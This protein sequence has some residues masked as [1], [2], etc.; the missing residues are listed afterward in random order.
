MGEF[1]G[2]RTQPGQP[3]GAARQ[4]FQNREGFLISEYRHDKKTLS[5]VNIIVL[6]DP[7]R[8]SFRISLSSWNSALVFVCVTG[9]LGAV[10]YAGIQF[11]SE[12]STGIVSSLREQTASIW[13]DELRAQ[14]E[15]L[16]EVKANAEWSLD[17]MA[18]RV[19]RLQ[20]H[21]MRLDALGSRL[22][23][24]AKLQ[25]M[26]F[27][28]ASP[29]GMGGPEPIVAQESID[30]PDF[31]FILEDIE[32]GLQDKEEKLS[33]MESMLIRRT[34]QE[35]TL[36]DG[37]PA[38]SSWVSSLF[39]FR[40]DPVTGKR[41]FHQ[42]ID[43]AGR[44]EAPITAVA[45][46]IVTWAGPRQGYGNLVEISHGNG[47]LTRYA[48]TRKNLVGVGEKVEK[49]EVIALMGDSGRATG[50]HVH[51]EVVRDGRHLNPRQQISLK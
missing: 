30:I 17:A 46:G 51:Y 37:S 27:A 12:R 25:D 44:P 3:V 38:P 1:G 43:F 40:S 8:K 9:C 15:T 42:G 32:R 45:A 10:F 22:A 23:A 41:E 18:S 2:P 16:A 48:H 14:R 31:L 24:M 20:G 7:R 21:V 47:Y 39:G 28:F 34:L 29:P 5:S 26:E 36:P 33:A 4:E 19:S 13:Q 6:L 11:G 50:T 35:Q 49:G